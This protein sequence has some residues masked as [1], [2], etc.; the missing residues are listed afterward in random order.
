[1][2][3][4]ESSPIFVSLF[5]NDSLL[6]S[7]RIITF[8]VT[9]QL[10][11][12]QLKSFVFHMQ[13]QCI[14]PYI[15]N[16]RQSQNRLTQNLITSLIVKK[17]ETKILRIYSLHNSQVKLDQSHNHICGDKN[18]TLL[19]CARLNNAKTNTL[20]TVNRHFSRWQKMAKFS[21]KDIN[22]RPSPLP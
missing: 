1:M 21:A 8:C 7:Y 2:I 20:N 6:V 16:K 11:R 13:N 22:T 19:G 12:T 10:C 18:L 4:H 5:N 9:T 17:L 3:I 15:T 14:L